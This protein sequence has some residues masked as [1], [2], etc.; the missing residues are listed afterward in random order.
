MALNADLLQAPFRKLRKA[1]KRFPKLPSPDEV[2][3]LRTQTRRLEAILH[4]LMLDQRRDGADLLET[5]APVR[6]AAGEVRDMDV[7]V[8]FASSLAIDSEDE[9]LVQLLEHLGN[10]RVKAAVELHRIIAGRKKEA[11]R[12]LTQCSKL[13][14]GEIESPRAADISG[15]SRP[16]ANAMAVSLQLEA[17][18]GVWP[19]LRADNLHP[20]RLKVKELRY[21]LQLAEDSDSAFIETLGEVKDTIGAWHELE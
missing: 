8:R 4:A 9:C 11:R 2:H 14:E 21:I 20:F 5:L 6:K 17:E 7:L 3:R 12:C 18:L 16:A 19:K 10:R 13:V 1:L 15:H